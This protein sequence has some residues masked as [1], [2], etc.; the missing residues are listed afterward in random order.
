MGYYHM[1]IA[2]YGRCMDF[3]TEQELREELR[4]YFTNS[5]LR[6]GIVD[7]LLTFGKPNEYG[8]AQNNWRDVTVTRFF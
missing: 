1:V 5:E 2:R 3:H 4:R 7:R 6:S 8:Y